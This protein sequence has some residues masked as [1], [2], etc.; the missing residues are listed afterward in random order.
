MIGGDRR[1][2][3]KSNS[4]YSEKIQFSLKNCTRYDWLLEVFDS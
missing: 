3:K 2:K 1:T 4:S